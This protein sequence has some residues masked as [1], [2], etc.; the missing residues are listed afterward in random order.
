MR[1]IGL[2]LATAFLALGLGLPAV[3]QKRGG[4]MVIAISGEP[5]AIVGF[6][7]TDTGG[8]NIASNLFAGLIGFNAE[9]EPVPNL[10]ESWTISPDGRTYRFNLHKNAVFHD[11]KPITAE[12]CEFT[13][14]EVVAKHH[15]SRGTWW[16]NVEHAKAIDKHTFEFKLKEPFPA[17]MALL[18]YELRSGALIV[19]KHIYA[20]SDAS[21]NPANEKPIG[22]GA[23]KF[24]KWVK[25]S[26]VEL[27]R[28]EKYFM[29]GKPYLDRLIIQFVPDPSTRILAFERGEVDFIDYTAVPHNEVKRFS[30]DKRFRVEKV[31]D[32][33]AVQGMWLFNT[34]NKPLSDVRVR[35][36]L[37][38]AIDTEEVADKALFGAGRTPHSFLNS[39]LGFLYS[40]KYDV[41]KRD[42][43][44]ANSMLDEAGV[45]RGPDGIRFKMSIDWTA[46]RPYD[47]KAAEVVRDQLRDV[48]VAAEIRVLDRPTFVEKVF[49]KW[50]FDSAMQL[51]STGPDPSISVVT[52]YHTKQI[53]RAPF[54]N[55][56]GYSNTELDKIFDADA[57]E[58]D[59]EKRKAYWDEAQKILMRDLP[60]IPVFEFP[61][62]HLVN[63]KFKNVVTGPY[64][65]FQSRHEAYME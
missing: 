20:G 64:G 23:F 31:R 33:I 37:Y 12:D 4:T 39:S 59:R 7:H 36:A 9:W 6:L 40:D 57:S 60:G 21:K 17:F 2:W 47:G 53:N 42:V 58:L 45:K 41:Y 15:P 44:K 56:M 38:Y 35:Q 32:A 49:A 5:N 43:A 63:N 50:E 25:G 26:H 65:Y 3:A 34:R 10:A 27:V 16:P 29:P 51:I 46:G 30:N 22:S 54:T 24:S 18:A 48:G 14:N 8:F 62:G 55:A 52:R 19:P 61:D 11:G 28:N 13:F 1:R